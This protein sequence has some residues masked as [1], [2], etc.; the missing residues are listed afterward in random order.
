MTRWQWSG[1]RKLFQSTLPARGSDKAEFIARAVADNFNPRSPQ[2]G[3]TVNPL[4]PHG[5][6][7]YFNPRSPQGG[8]T[9]KASDDER[10]L[11]SIS[12]HAPRK[13]ERLDTSTATPLRRVFQSTLPAR[14]SDVV[15]GRKPP[16]CQFISIHAPRKGER[17]GMIYNLSF[18]INISIHAP[19]KGERLYLPIYRAIGHSISIHAPRKGERQLT[20]PMMRGENIFQSTFPARGSDPVA[21]VYP[22]FC[23]GISIHAPRK[24]E[25]PTA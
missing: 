3:A 11:W 10:D 9:R 24:G 13:G 7:K 5:P 12:I 15:H 4:A 23:G 20:S 22:V 17:H 18:V 2:G 25:R 8:A 14:G 19:R 1:T 16:R 21:V 6:R